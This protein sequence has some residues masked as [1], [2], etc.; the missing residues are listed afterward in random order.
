MTRK[1]RPP[2][3]FAATA[4]ILAAT[5]LIPE[6]IC[7][8]PS[9]NPIATLVSKP[10]TQ[11]NAPSASTSSAP[12]DEVVAPD[13]PRASVDAYLQLC[14]VGRY[15]DAAKYLSVAAS[16]AKRSAELARRLK[17]VLDTDF[18]IDL[19]TLSPL[20]EGVRNDLL[21][22]GH[23]QIGQIVGPSGKAGPLRL[24]RI[25]F[26]GPD[27]RWVFSRSTV[28][29][30]DDWY[31]RLEQRWFL[32][33]LPKYLLKVG[34]RNLMIWQWIGLPVLFAASWVLGYLLSRLSCNVL[35]RA[36]KRTP[37]TWDNDLVGR[38]GGPLTLAWMQSLV[39]GLLPWLGLYELA[40]D[41][42][43]GLLRGGLY[44]CLFWAISRL[45]DVWGRAITASEWG[46]EHSASRSLVPLGVRLGKIAVLVVAMVALVSAFGYPA[47]SLLAGLGVGGLAL[48]L[49]AQKTVENLFGAFS[50]GADQ[51]FREGDFIKVDDFTGTVESLGLRSTRIRTLDRTL[52]SIPNG[53]LSEMRVESYAARDRLRL[54]CTI[55]LVYDTTAEQMRQVLG[56]LEELLRN[57][58]KIWSENISVRFKE[59]GSSALNIEVMAWFLTA[60]Y[61]EFQTIR[62]EVLLS[63]ME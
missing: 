30:I 15:Q 3:S 36:A 34:P 59:F 26:P 8:A 63:F 31:D 56:D 39:Y 18:W 33:H 23:E 21:P 55:G 12:T 44:F 45:I 57:H 4:F 60:D 1:R 29:Q 22:P 47:A 58:P 6:R 53:K 32:D 46:R 51:P 27:A 19:D 16:Q 2:L 24:T 14:K 9:I 41:F 52:I 37:S 48:A 35:A 10:V 7:A 25:A 13:S 49:A 28:D 38:L 5:L 11:N 61:A 43:K 50:I 54:F 17:A 20:S 62:Q 40:Q 42:V